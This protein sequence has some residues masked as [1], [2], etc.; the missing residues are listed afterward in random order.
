MDYPSLGSIICRLQ[1]RDINN[2]PTHTSRRYETAL[3]ERRFQ[4][5]AINSSLLLLLPP[6]M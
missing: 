4:L 1:L 3:P 5:L 6:P 2:M